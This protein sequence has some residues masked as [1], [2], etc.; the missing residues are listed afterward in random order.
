MLN[1]MVLH[2]TGLY[3]DFCRENDVCHDYLFILIM[4][5]TYNDD[6]GTEMILEWRENEGEDGAGVPDG[7]S[8]DNGMG[9]E[10]SAGVW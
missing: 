5:H 3:V 6:V 7:V 2:G 4:N 8:T 9:M 10:D 1:A